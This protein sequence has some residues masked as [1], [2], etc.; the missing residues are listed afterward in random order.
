MSSLR[1][2]HI[3]EEGDIQKFHPRKSKEQWGY[4]KYVWAIDEGKIHNYLLPRDCPR[5][6][7][8]LERTGDQLNWLKTFSI[9]NHKAVIFICYEWCEKIQACTLFQYE[10]GKRNFEPIDKVAGYFVSRMV[11]TPI[12][13]FVIR[14]CEQE[15]S[16]LNVKLI[17]LDRIKML[18]IKEKVVKD[19][20][21]FSIIK[22]ENFE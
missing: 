3:S 10:F 17:Q 22:W 12:Q 5:I 4:H 1:L 20:E 16:R 19:L 14:N 7:I 21:S 11:E 15:L 8:D 13:R 18:D 2:F 9:E 6:C